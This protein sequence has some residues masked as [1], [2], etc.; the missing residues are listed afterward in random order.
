MNYLPPARL[1]LVPKLKKSSDYIE[2]WHMQYFKY[3]KLYF[4]VKNN[5]Y[6]IFTTC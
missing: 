3:A 1:K 6:E 2:I 5:F 4:N